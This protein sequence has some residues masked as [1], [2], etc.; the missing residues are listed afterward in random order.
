MLPLSKS[1]SADARRTT[2]LVR[3]V[4]SAERSSSSPHQLQNPRALGARSP[5]GRKQP[6]LSHRPECRRGRLPRSAL[7]DTEQASEAQ[8]SVS[9]FLVGLWCR[10]KAAS[11]RCPSTA[12]PRLCMIRARPTGEADPRPAWCQGEKTPLPA[13]ETANTP[14][15]DAYRQ[16]HRSNDR[17]SRLRV[18]NRHSLGLQPQSSPLAVTSGSVNPSAFTGEG[19]RST[20]TSWSLYWSW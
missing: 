4:F 7:G 9:Y 12:A 14:A 11:R 1:E 16:R 3:A 8:C 5:T 10:A 2:P 17:S 15:W 13:L 20:P 6:V 18:F 19:A